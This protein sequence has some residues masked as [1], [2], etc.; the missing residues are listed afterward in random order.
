MDC[1]DSKAIFEQQGGISTD[2]I[3]HSISQRIVRYL[4]ISWLISD[5]FKKWLN[6]VEYYCAQDH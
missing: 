1:I 2:T 6:N 5:N 4:S 3:L